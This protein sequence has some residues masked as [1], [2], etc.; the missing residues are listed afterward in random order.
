[1]ASLEEIERRLAALER[2]VDEEA[3]LRAAVDQD[4]A[5]QGSRIRAMHHLV[6]AVAITQSDQGDK[7][8]RLHEAVSAQSRLII[9][10]TTAIMNQL[11][12]IIDRRDD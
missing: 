1:M 6:Q 7:L 8:E 11:N 12:E 5:D 2:R 9:E 4:Q 10:R 3:G